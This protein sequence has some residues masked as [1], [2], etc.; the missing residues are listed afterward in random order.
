MAVAPAAPD[1]GPPSPPD[2]N[3]SVRLIKDVLKVGNW[4]TGYDDAGRPEMWAVTPAVLAN[5]A[6]DFDAMKANG[7][8]SNLGK[9]HGD[10]NLLIHPDDLIAPIEAVKVAGDTLWIAS[11]VTPEQAKYLENPAMK[12]S[13]GVVPNWQDGRGKTYSMALVHVAVTD[14]PVVAGQG[15]FLALADSVK[16]GSMNPELV[17]AINMLMEAAGLSA[18]GDVVD[19]AD[20]ISQLKGVSAALGKTV[21]AAEETDT[22]VP[23]EGGD[24]AAEIPLPGM[25]PALADTIRK[26]IKGLDDRVVALSDELA[27]RRKADVTAAK[28]AFHTETGR[29]LGSGVPKA[30]IDKKIA[31]A[32]KLGSYD[33]AL[34]DGLAP[35]LNTGRQS[36]A[37][38]LAD[39]S[40]PNVSTTDVEADRKERAAALAR[41]RGISVDEAMKF[42]T[43]SA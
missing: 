32:D 31:L 22:T 35:V 34:L 17:D 1:F 12:V 43:P 2:A 38:K 13:V 42:I 29:L 7:V 26:V 8:G 41:R 11:Y 9:T 27:Q 33:V 36:L 20:L 23:A 19:E 4:K 15:P 24:M 3:R 28:A 30:T 25:A 14:R 16:G 18:L 37:R 40:P 10:E 39:A 21:A 6:R 5:I